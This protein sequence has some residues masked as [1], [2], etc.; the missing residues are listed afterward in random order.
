MQPSRL[1][2]GRLE[3]LFGQIDEA[4]FLFSST[5]SEAHL[6]SLDSGVACQLRGAVFRWHV[7]PAPRFLDCLNREVLLGLFGLFDTF[8]PIQPCAKTLT[9]F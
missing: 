9:D 8:I 2:L 6:S 3:A 7:A 1:R 4:P 5:S